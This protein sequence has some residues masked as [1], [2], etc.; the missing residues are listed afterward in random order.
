M[1]A[2][3]LLTCSRGLFGP[4][5]VRGSNS[6]RTNLKVARPV[7]KGSKIESPLGTA[8]ARDSADSPSG[9]KLMS[10]SRNWPHCHN[11]LVLSA[12]FGTDSCWTDAML[13]MLRA[14]GREVGAADVLSA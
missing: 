13:L 3:I 4:V 5:P 11:M 12:P 9:V 6:E 8:I 2:V 7:W 10:W 1:Y 14:P